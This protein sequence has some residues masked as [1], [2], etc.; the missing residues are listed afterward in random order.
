MLCYH[1]IT[2][3]SIFISE[4]HFIWM[5]LHFFDCIQFF[6]FLSLQY[7]YKSQAYVISRYIENPLLVGGRKFDLRIYVL[8]TSY[9][10]LKVYQYVHIFAF[11]TFFCA[12]YFCFVHVYLFFFFLLKRRSLFSV[13]QFYKNKSSKQEDHLRFY[14]SKLPCVE[15]DSSTYVIPTA[16]RVKQWVNATPAGFV[17]HFKAHQIFTHGNTDYS[18]LPKLIRDGF[19]HPQ[20]EQ[21]KEITL[22]E[23]PEGLQEQL[24]FLFTLRPN[25]S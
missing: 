2:F 9:R 16:H 10:P 19:P 22:D 14:S 21:A 6:L 3:I 12:F 17:F 13:P 1:I 11:F 7:T 15:V 20:G 8:V 5:V 24:M 4:H 23:I 25:W 18:K